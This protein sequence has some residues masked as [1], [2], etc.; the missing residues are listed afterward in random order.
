MGIYNGFYT[1]FD[2]LNTTKKN[3]IMRTY[4]VVDMLNEMYLVNKNSVIQS[5]YYDDKKDVLYVAGDIVTVKWSYGWL[6]TYIKGTK[7]RSY[8]RKVVQSKLVEKQFTLYEVVAEE[9]SFIIYRAKSMSGVDC[10]V[11]IDER[12]NLVSKVIEIEKAKQIL[13]EELKKIEYG[14]LKE[15][16]RYAHNILPDP[17]LGEPNEIY[18]T[19]EEFNISSSVP[20]FEEALSVILKIQGENRKL[21]SDEVLSLRDLREAIDDLLG[22]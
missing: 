9:P 12:D 1:D 18:R 15:E 10:Y 20:V 11:W 4:N 17:K 7:T 8:I 22:E 6:I 14:K 13:E 16:N 21:A 5:I 19:P 2:E 3:T